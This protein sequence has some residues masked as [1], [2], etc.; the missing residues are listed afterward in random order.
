MFVFARE[1]EVASIGDVKVGGQ[2]GQVPTLL[3]GTLFY[4]KQFE[5][6]D[7]DALKKAADL[8]KVQETHA[9]ETSLHGLVD[10][11]IKSE[12]NIK[13]EI[14]CVLDSTDKPFSIDVSESAV[15]IKAL[16]YLKKAGALDRTIYNS[17]NLGITE[18]EIKAL[19]KHTPAAA[20][21]LAYNPKDTTTNGRLEILETGANLVCGGKVQK[22]LL[23]V[24]RDCGI[25]ALLV[26]TASTPFGQNAGDALR[27]IP[28][29]KSEHGL[30]AGCAIHNTLESWGWMK[31]YRKKY[32]GVYDVVDVVANALV[33]V[34]AGDYTIYGPIEQAPRVLP[35]IAFA[36]K[37]VAE[38]ASDYFGTEPAK[39]HPYWRLE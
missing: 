7:K 37:L 29:V 17:V 16:E 26:D 32:D 5:K 38:G 35:S 21:V 31:D 10:V 4:G 20:I 23:D 6:L 25:K 18:A 11:Y 3:L 14:D 9:K 12:K 36:D 19:K 30:P 15:R 34:Y 24:A 39:N 2:P 27:A 13:P 22:G 1:Q 28:V 33:A 8:I